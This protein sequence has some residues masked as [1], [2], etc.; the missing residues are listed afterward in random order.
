M[1]IKLGIKKSLLALLNPQNVK[2][3]SIEGGGACVFVCVCE[4]EKGKMK[5]FDDKLLNLIC[6]IC[7]LH[8]TDVFIVMQPHASQLERLDLS[9]ILA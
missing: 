7:D 1:N 2:C 8:Y 9:L 4:V 3:H 5:I 6:I